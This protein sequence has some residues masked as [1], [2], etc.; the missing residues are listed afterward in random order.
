MALAWVSVVVLMAMRVAGDEPPM[1]H[2]TQPDLATTVLLTDAVHETGARCLDGSPQRYWIQ[3][4]PAG[5]TNATKWSF[6]H[7]GGGWCESIESCTTRAYGKDCYIGSS[8]ES[9]FAT[10]GARVPGMSP[11]FNT[12]MDFRHIPSCL[13]ARWCGGLMMNDPALNPVTW[14]WN[15]VLLP[16]CDG[17]SFSGNNESV[18]WVQVDGETKPLYFRGFRNF[19]AV[20]NDLQRNHALGQ[21]TDV[22][23]SGDSAG[24]LATYYHVDTY[25]SVLPKAIVR[26]APD[27]GFFFYDSTYPQWG[28]SLD[29]VVS[30]MNSTAGLNQACVRDHVAK[31]MDPLQCRFPEVTVEHVQ[32]P[33]FVL[34]SKIDPALDEIVGGERGGNASNV[35]RMA[36]ELVALVHDRVLSKPHNA[37]FI[38]SCHEHC[39]QWAQDQALGPQGQ[40]ADFNV[41][42]DGLT[43]PKAL[44]EW[45]LGNVAP[46][47]LWLQAAD[48]PCKTCC[49]GGQE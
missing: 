18:T 22:V 13:G 32:T 44:N 7:M 33:L 47:K 8:N 29:W 41:T 49:H 1:L 31:G 42:I 12:T 46:S 28:K 20:L 6:H 17:G 16:Y 25:A 38:T 15:K 14:D 48:Y 10:A 11:P 30:Y 23:V 34:N 5:S 27:S 36:G 45:I 24:G 40:F 19:M 35:N 3:H 9:C 39:G 21:A 37:A 43:A 2:G 4:A 26:G